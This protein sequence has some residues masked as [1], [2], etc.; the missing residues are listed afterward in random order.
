[1]QQSTQRMPQSAGIDAVGWEREVARLRAAE[2][3]LSHAGG[4]PG[5]AG[6]R[7]V[8]QPCKPASHML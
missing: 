3:D 7:G 1:M 2:P 6:L 4:H 5:P 8:T